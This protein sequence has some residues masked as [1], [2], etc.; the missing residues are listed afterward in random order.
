MYIEKIHL[1][2]WKSY[3]DETYSFPKPT[4]NKNVVLVGAQNGY[5]KTSLLEAIMLCLYGRDGLSHIPRATLIEGDQQKLDLSY[6]EFL[7]RA[8]HGCALG[9]G[10]NSASVTVTL[11]DDGQRTS[12]TRQWY[13][14]GSGK[15]RH[16]EEEV[17]IY[18]DDE[19]FR[20]GR[21]DDKQDAVRNFIAKTFVPVF[22]APFFLFDGEQVQRL[23]N[24]EMAA[25][26]R[27]GI[28][29]LL[30]VAT[31]RELQADL[32][33]YALNRKSG[34]A[35]DGDNTTEVLESELRSL[36]SDQRKSQKELQE[37]EPRLPGLKQAKE[38][39]VR[40]LNSIAGGNSATIKELY[41]ERSKAD[42]RRMHF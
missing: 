25:Q 30:G 19:P 18:Q 29:G 24:K 35:T 32:R 26:V 6:D 9:S 11:N 33:E 23:A 1:R 12:V 41:D 15:H 22:L 2:D 20:A 14:A 34:L 27:T 28:E 42:S 5:G 17:R 39:K 10:R 31:L 37:L 16:S 13:F 8:F 40:Q 3:V 21:F 7:R 38:A 36:V 4:R